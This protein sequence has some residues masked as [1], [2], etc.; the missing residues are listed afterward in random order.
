L[1]YYKF[2]TK[3]CYNEGYRSNYKKWHAKQ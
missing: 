3:Q 1:C 2:R